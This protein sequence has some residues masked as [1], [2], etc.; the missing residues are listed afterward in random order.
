MDDLE[1]ETGKD[2]SDGAVALGLKVMNKA[3][4]ACEDS[5]FAADGE[6]ERHQRNTLRI[7]G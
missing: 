2:H 5:F 7:Q 4:D 6:W 1:G 3:D